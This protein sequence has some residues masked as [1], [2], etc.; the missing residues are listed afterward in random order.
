MKIFF[1]LNYENNRN[2]MIFFWNF[3]VTIIF[4][5]TTLPPFVATTEGAKNSSRE[6]S[7]LGI[8]LTKREKYMRNDYSSMSNF[9]N[10]FSLLYENSIILQKF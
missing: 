2:K 5:I 4:I 7:I 8:I 3:F 1:L 6:S 9:V 10:I